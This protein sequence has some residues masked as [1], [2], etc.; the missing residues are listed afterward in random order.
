MLFDYYHTS[1]QGGHFGVFKTIQKIRE[2]FIWKD[3]DNDIRLRVRHCIVCNRL[4]IPAPSSRFGLLASEVATRPFQKLFIDYVGKFPLSKAGNTM[5][6]VCVDSFP[7]LVWL[8]PG[9]EATSSA[10]IRVLKDRVFAN[11]SVPSVLVSDDAR[12]F[13]SREFQQFCFDL[14]IKHVTSTPHYP[15][16]SHAERFNCTLRSALIAY[17]GNS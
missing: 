6:L 17:Y 4:S 16:P 13:T 10:M 7:K 9:W 12:C 15:Q 3:V 1:P 5:L 2:N 11:F 14:G 8:T